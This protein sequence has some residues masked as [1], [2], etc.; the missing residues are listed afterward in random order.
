MIYISFLLPKKKAPK[1]PPKE[2]EGYEYNP[3]PHPPY[4]RKSENAARHFPDE[5][6]GQRLLA[7]GFKPT[8]PPSPAT[9]LRVA[10]RISPRWH[11]IS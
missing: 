8:F 5:H 6:G 2:P 11:S 9:Q 10:C 4:L 7:P 3:D 1:L